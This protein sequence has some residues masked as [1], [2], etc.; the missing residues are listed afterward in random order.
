MSWAGET[1]YQATLLIVVSCTQ[2][3]GA[4]QANQF[5]CNKSKAYFT[6]LK[7]VCVN[8]I[9]NVLSGPL[10]LGHYELTSY[11]NLHLLPCR[12]ELHKAFSCN[13]LIQTSPAIHACT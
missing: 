11:R 12:L 13:M 1:V 3:D 2:G 5:C 7:Y 10:A 4:F 8:V 6:G 9:G